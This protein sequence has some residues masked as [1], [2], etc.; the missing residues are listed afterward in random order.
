MLAIQMRAYVSEI[1]VLRR[2]TDS[3]RR[4]LREQYRAQEAPLI[5]DNRRRLEAA[6]Q[7]L[8]RESDDRHLRLNL[9]FDSVFAPQ[10]QR[11]EDAGHHVPR[12]GVGTTRVREIS[13]GLHVPD[14][15]LLDRRHLAPLD[16]ASSHV[17]GDSSSSS[18]GM[19]ASSALDQETRGPPGLL[20]GV[21][22]FDTILSFGPPSTT[23]H[24]T[25]YEVIFG[26]LPRQQSPLGFVGESGPEEFLSS[27]L[28]SLA[29]GRLG[30]APA[31]MPPIYDATNR[32]DAHFLVSDSRY[33]SP[34]KPCDSCGRVVFNGQD[35]C[36]ACTGVLD[37]DPSFWFP[38]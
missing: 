9:Q 27:A 25:D 13:G 30:E 11:G 38:H 32:P 18:T 14:V 21:S 26:A 29:D 2:E 33:A 22:A 23:P 28:S 20:P 19:V 35:V 37:T 3:H 17:P 6:E 8:D 10:Q 15:L 1:E 36:D 34:H 5:Q 31:T 24:D 7:Q 4:R 12:E 16:S